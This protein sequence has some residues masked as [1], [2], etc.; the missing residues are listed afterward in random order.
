MI[1]ELGITNMVQ[2]GDG[3]FEAVG[4]DACGETGY[5]GRLCVTEILTVND[6]IQTAILQ[7]ASETDIAR[8]AVEGGMCSMYRDGMR[9]ALAGDTTVEEVLRVTREEE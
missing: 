8:T 1:R 7:N 5:S 9:K 2:P 3:L 4:C 6:A